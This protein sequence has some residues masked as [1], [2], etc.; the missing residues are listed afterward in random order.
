MLAT[1]QAR[2]GA[3]APLQKALDAYVAAA[4]QGIDGGQVHAANKA[5]IEAVAIGQQVLAGQ[6]WTDSTFQTAYK[7][8]LASL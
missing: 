5:A 8:A 1:L 7:T 2:A 4:N 3:D 6:F